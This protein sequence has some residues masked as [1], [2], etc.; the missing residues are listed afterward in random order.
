MI[1]SAGG[2][3]RDG[4]LGGA[5]PS[6]LGGNSTSTNYQEKT[7]TFQLCLSLASEWSQRRILVGL[8]TYQNLTECLLACMHWV[9]HRR[10]TK[11]LKEVYHLLE[12]ADTQ[13]DNP[14]E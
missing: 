14:R 10:D 6:S 2:E 1:L 8:V 5:V 11:I 13:A 9:G 12:E 7:G 4:Q 3:L